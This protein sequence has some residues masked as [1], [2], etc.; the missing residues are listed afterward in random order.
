MTKKEFLR[1]L[2]H[3]LVIL[4]KHCD[5][6]CGQELLHQDCK[7]WLIIYTEELGE[8]REKGGFQKNFYMLKRTY[9]ISEALSLSRLCFPL[10]KH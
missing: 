1:C 9:Q 3:K 7:E 4:L 2:W 5:W 6:T 8:V 10:A